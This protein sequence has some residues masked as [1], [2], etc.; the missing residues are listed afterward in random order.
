MRV[1]DDSAGRE[2]QKHLALVGFMGA[3][4][5]TIGRLLAERLGLP[6][7]DTDAELEKAHRLSVGEIFSQRGE[8]Q[9]RKA[10]REL[11]LGL[12]AGE[13][14][15]L[16]VGG[17]AYV[18]EEVREAL[19]RQATVIWLDPPFELILERLSRSGSRPL[20]SGRSAEELRRLWDAR[21]GVYVGAH[22]HV[23]T[24]DAEPLSFVETIL[25]QLG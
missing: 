11:I 10:E 5:S 19:D 16:S 1:V 22:I 8:A 25:R 14:Q 20:A 3:G 9:F 21:R 15:V 24:S 6:F 23:R 4:K 12:L 13:P 17:G 18:D 7:V 2:G